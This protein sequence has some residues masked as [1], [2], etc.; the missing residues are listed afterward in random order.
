MAW[1][2]DPALSRF[3]Q[4]RFSLNC[5][6]SSRFKLDRFPHLRHKGDHKFFPSQKQRQ[7]RLKKRNTPCVLS[8]IHVH[9]RLEIKA[10][11]DEKG[12]CREKFSGKSECDAEEGDEKNRMMMKVFVVS[13]RKKKGFWH[14]SMLPSRGEAVTTTERTRNYA[15]RSRL[16]PHRVGSTLTSF[17]LIK[18]I[19]E[20]KFHF[21][22]DR[23]M[24]ASCSSTDGWT[25]HNFFSGGGGGFIFTVRREILAGV[26]NVNCARDE[27]FT[28]RV[29]SSLRSMKKPQKL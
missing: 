5:G 22:S 10:I 13:Q 25:T 16:T 17:N 3:Y 12:K 28:R 20:G 27:K 2:L 7:M 1:A 18:R 23:L 6:A 4:F 29:G 26:E 14:F 11:F 9:L 8:E 19:S 21:L 24:V 15:P